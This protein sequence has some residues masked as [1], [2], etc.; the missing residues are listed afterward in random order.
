MAEELRQRPDQQRHQR[1]NA[2][3]NRRAEWTEP[4]EGVAEIDSTQLFQGIGIQRV[5]RPALAGDPHVHARRVP[6]PAAAVVQP[7]SFAQPL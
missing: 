3:R 5:G 6:E 4:G 2:Q 7:V 1:R